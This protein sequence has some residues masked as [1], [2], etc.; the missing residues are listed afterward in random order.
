MKITFYD[1]K[2]SVF[3]TGFLIGAFLTFSFLATAFVFY[4]LGQ[5]G[6]GLSPGYVM[7]KVAS[8]LQMPQIRKGGVSLV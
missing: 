3:I 4:K 7:Q 5:K 8:K 1:S 6:A 2:K